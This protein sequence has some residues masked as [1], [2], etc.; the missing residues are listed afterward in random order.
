MLVPHA[1]SVNEEER[2]WIVD[3]GGL[4]MIFFRTAAV[5]GL[6]EEYAFRPNPA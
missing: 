2:E 4:Q 6:R 5:G 1:V 3:G